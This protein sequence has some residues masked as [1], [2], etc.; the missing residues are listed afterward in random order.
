MRNSLPSSEG[1]GRECD[2]RRQG[3]VLCEP[4]QTSPHTR[5]SSTPFVTIHMALPSDNHRLTMVK[6]ADQPRLKGLLWNVW[7][8]NL[9]AVKVIWNVCH[10]GL[11]QCPGERINNYICLGAWI[12][13]LVK[14]RILKKKKGYWVRTLS[15]MTQHFSWS[16]F[17]QWWLVSVQ[18]DIAE[19]SQKEV[20]EGAWRLS[21]QSLLCL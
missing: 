20:C 15:S 12:W 8:V 13:L 16:R 9:K 10:C 1:R 4:Q 21:I 19:S 17:S 3:R 5:V 11:P 6:P 2:E 7:L 18:C 14:K